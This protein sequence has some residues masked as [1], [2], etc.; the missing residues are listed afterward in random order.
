MRFHTLPLPFLPSISTFPPAHGTNI[1]SLLTNLVGNQMIDPKCCYQIPL[2]ALPLL[3]CLQ[4]PILIWEF[5]HQRCCFSCFQ[6]P[7]NHLKT[8]QKHGKSVI[9]VTKWYK[10]VHLFPIIW[11]WLQAWKRK[12]MNFHCNYPWKS[13]WNNVILDSWNDYSHISIR[14]F[15]WTK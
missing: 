11:R 13:L 2:G 3:L 10:L 5:S 12:K 8:K 1:K 9:D 4:L 6:R 14:C 7:P 15:R